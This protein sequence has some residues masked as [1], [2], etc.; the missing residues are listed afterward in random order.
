MKILIGYSLQERA[1]ALMLK[2]SI[3][4]AGHEVWL[5]P[6]ESRPPERATAELGAAGPQVVLVLLSPAAVSATWL[7]GRFAQ[8]GE[9]VREM[10]PIVVRACAIPTIFADRPAL[11]VSRDSDHG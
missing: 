3:E 10:I 7:S 9:P 5:D 4:F 11:D 2:H 6:F 1:L 8:S